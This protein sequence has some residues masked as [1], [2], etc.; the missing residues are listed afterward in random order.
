MHYQYSYGTSFIVSE[1][2]TIIT[3][4]PDSYTLSDIAEIAP[5]QVAEL[6]YGV[7]RPSES[8]LYP[9]D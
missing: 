4:A 2:T 9:F 8:E 3:L 5:R 6:P 1:M 7:R